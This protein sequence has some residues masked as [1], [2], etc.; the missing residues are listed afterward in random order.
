MTAAS[1]RTEQITI[2]MDPEAQIETPRGPV[3]VGEWLRAERWRLMESAVWA[4]VWVAPNAAGSVAMFGTPDD[5][6]PWLAPAA[7]GVAHA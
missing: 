4:D 1:E 6:A 3:I 7:T 5:S 2:F